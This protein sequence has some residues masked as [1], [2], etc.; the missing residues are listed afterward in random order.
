MCKENFKLPCINAM[1]WATCIWLF[2]IFRCHLLI[3]LCLWVLTPECNVIC[4]AIDLM[5]SWGLTWSY[6]QRQRPWVILESQTLEPFPLASS[7]CIPN[8]MQTAMCSLGP[9][10]S[11]IWLGDGRSW[12][13][14]GIPTFIRQSEA[15][16]KD[17]AMKSTRIKHMKAEQGSKRRVAGSVLCYRDLRWVRN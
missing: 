2:Y 12:V 9:S 15:E 11:E 1:L 17:L 14:W 6:E 8:M 3:S 7:S 13:W 4:L 10:E 16:N 5:L